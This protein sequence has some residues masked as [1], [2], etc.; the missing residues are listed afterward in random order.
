MPTPRGHRDASSSQQTKCHQ[1]AQAPRTRESVKP[2]KPR[3]RRCANPDSVAEF[4]SFGSPSIGE[5]PCPRRLFQGSAVER[6]ARAE[7]CGRIAMRY[8]S[9][10]C[11]RSPSVFA[12]APAAAQQDAAHLGARLLQDAAVKPALDGRARRRAADARG[13]GRICEVEAPPF[14]EAKR[15]RALR[16]DVPRARAAER[17][18]RQGGQRA[19]RAARAQ[20][21]PHLVLQRAPRHRVP[22]RHQ[23]HGQA[24]RRGRCVARA[25]ATTAAAWRSCWPS[26]ARMSRRQRPDARHDHVRGQRSAKKGWATCAA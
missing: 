17:A 19:R 10:P 9:T 23:R 25:S 20:P 8:A 26:S 6:A 21:R 22:R 16:R 5:R 18:H 7:R 11:S 4:S 3:R 13:P 1:R 24:R 2:L 15:G 14:K 12:A